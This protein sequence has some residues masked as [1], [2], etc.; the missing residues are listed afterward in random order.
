MISI[1]HWGMFEDRPENGRIIN[2]YEYELAVLAVVNVFV[3]STKDCLVPMTATEAT[4]RINRYGIVNEVL[5]QL[6]IKV[7]ES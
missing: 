5:N 3:K 1:S 7:A 2:A 6:G 4:T